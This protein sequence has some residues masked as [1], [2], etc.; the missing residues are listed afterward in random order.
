MLNEKQQYN[1]NQ[2]LPEANQP[3][4]QPVNQ[5]PT[6][7]QNLQQPAP[8]NFNSDNQNNGSKKT[9][10]FII[11]IIAVLIIGGVIGA[12]LIKKAGKKIVERGIEKN[13]E[14]QFGNNAKVNIN[15]KEI[16]IKTE[17]GTFKMGKD[18]KIPK[19]CPKDV[20]IYP[21]AKITTVS[22]G[23]LYE[24]S[25]SMTTQ[26]QTTR[27]ANYYE[28]EL[29]KNGWKAKTNRITIS[30][31]IKL[32][33]IKQGREMGIIIMDDGKQRSIILAVNPQEKNPSY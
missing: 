21:A 18:V 27:I 12:I 33:Y 4:E 19:N 6:N 29:V 26:D 31:M 1:P 20:P 13:I 22:C 10:L 8:Q 7:N 15:K 25:L 17:K 3:A 14:R 16:G 5:Q 32:I 9:W 24:M 30:T 11:I 2:N 23:A 28:K